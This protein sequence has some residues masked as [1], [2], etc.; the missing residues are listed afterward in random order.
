MVVDLLVF[1]ELCP[2]SL[3]DSSN[4]VLFAIARLGLLEFELFLLLLDADDPAEED[5]IED[6]TELDD[7]AELSAKTELED[8]NA[9]SSI[10][11]SSCGSCFFEF[12]ECSD[13]SFKINSF[14]TEKKEMKLFTFVWG[15]KGSSIQKNVQTK[16]MHCK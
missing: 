15:E 13:F 4:L 14:T 10:P 6:L 12:F 5:C 9:P 16:I 2:E 8:D 7:F 3:L 1:I 11:S